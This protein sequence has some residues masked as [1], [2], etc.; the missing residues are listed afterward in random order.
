LLEALAPD[1]RGLDALL[2]HYRQIGEVESAKVVATYYTNYLTDHLRT[3]SELDKPR[4]LERLSSLH[5]YLDSPEEAIRLAQAASRLAPS[6][7][8]L[9]LRLGRLLVDANRF[10]EAQIELQWCLRRKPDHAELLTLLATANRN[11]LLRQADAATTPS[12]RD[13]NRR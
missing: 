1:Q 10:E 8:D 12:S 7:F 6:D 11:S 9:R 5:E 4:A 3:D 2:N 13:S